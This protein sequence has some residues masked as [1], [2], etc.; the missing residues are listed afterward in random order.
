MKRSKFQYEIENAYFRYTLGNNTKD[1]KLFNKISI[2]IFKLD[3]GIKLNDKDIELLRYISVPE[4]FISEYSNFS[5]INKKANKYKTSQKTK[6]MRILCC[7]LFTSFLLN[8]FFLYR[9]AGKLQEIMNQKYVDEYYDIV[10]DFADFLSEN[11]CDTPKEICDNFEGIL[12][13]EFSYYDS[14]QEDI[15][16]DFIGESTNI[17]LFKG[18]SDSPMEIGGVEDLVEVSPVLEGNR[19][20]VHLKVAMY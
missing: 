18:S 1:S 19:K 13:L 7:A 5:Q 8:D 9:V 10:S 12:N 17:S 15:F 3:L 4:D 14:N 6:R 16:L 2:I 20:A 11:G